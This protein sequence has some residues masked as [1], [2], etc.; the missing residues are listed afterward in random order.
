MPKINSLIYDGIPDGNEGLT[1]SDH[2][3]N[4]KTKQMKLDTV[5]DYVGS[6]TKVVSLII[7]YSSGVISDDFNNTQT[8]QLPYTHRQNNDVYAYYDK[9]GDDNIVAYK[10]PYLEVGKTYGYDKELTSEADFV[11]LASGG[12]IGDSARVVNSIAE[13][14][15]IQSVI[16]GDVVDTISYYGDNNG[17]GNRF[18]LGYLDYT[19]SE[20]HTSEL[21]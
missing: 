12:G 18:S 21:Q 2:N 20:E 15:A 19:K 11:E 17:G 16:L 5:K 10:M 4:G 1:M 8:E 9:L 13:L 14:R 7:P 3:D 6:G